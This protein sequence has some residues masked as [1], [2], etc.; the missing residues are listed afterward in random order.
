MK[1][2]TINEEYPMN[3]TELKELVRDV[4]REEL[5]KINLKEE[6]EGPCYMIKAW[7]SPED[8]KSGAPAFD[9]VKTGKKYKDFEEVLSALKT[10]ELSDLGAYEINWIKSGEALVES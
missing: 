10:N 9:S 6:V 4:I 3:E 8:K 7:A 2:T 5:D 1:M